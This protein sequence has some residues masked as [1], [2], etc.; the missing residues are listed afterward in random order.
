MKKIDNK[1]LWSVSFTSKAYKQ[2]EKLPQSMND[3]LFNL[4]AELEME[5]PIQTEWYHFGKLVRKKSNLYHCH[6]NKGKPRYVT[7]WYIADEQE[8]TIKICY[9]GTHEKVN[10]KKI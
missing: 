4:K 9:V 8:K 2:A 10:Y 5:G 1:T 7:I 6:L 3:V